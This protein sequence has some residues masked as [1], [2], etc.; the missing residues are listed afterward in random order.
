MHIKWIISSIRIRLQW[1][2]VNR[3]TAVVLIALRVL[4]PTTDKLP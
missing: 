2:Y 1:N 3:T 4:V